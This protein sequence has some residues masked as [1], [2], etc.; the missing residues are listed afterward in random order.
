MRIRYGNQKNIPSELANIMGFISDQP[1]DREELIKTFV[2]YFKEYY[3]NLT[4]KPHLEY[5][6]N[7]QFIKNFPQPSAK[8]P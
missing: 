4:Q 2:E 7:K 8:I 6:K 3:E 1:I 5:Y